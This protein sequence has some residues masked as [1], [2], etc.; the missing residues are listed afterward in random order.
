[1]YNR[2]KHTLIQDRLDATEVVLPRG[3]EHQIASLLLSKLPAAT[4]PSKTARQQE[5][6]PHPKLISCP[7]GHALGLVTQ[8]YR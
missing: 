4:L 1:M 2:G 6:L 8:G 5:T 3:K 7:A